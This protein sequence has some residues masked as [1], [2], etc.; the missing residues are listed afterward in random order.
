MRLS[1]R[2]RHP[3]A[4]Q[5]RLTPGSTS[6]PTATSRRWARRRC[7]RCSSC[8]STWCGASRRPFSSPMGA[9]ATGAQCRGW[10]ASASGLLC[11]TSWDALT[12]LLTLGMSHFA[13]WLVGRAVL[14]LASTLVLGAGLGMPAAI[15]L[16][17][18][19]ACEAIAGTLILTWS[20][21]EAWGPVPPPRHRH[22][23]RPHIRVGWPERVHPC[24]HG[25]PV[26]HHRLRH[27]V[28]APVR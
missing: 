15:T 16:L 2:L 6:S 14:A 5:S 13:A 22:R 12:T 7:G 1:R 9:P 28:A 26:A 10:A 21:V 20:R 18:M 25:A 27:L 23:R 3:V 8:P 4:V 17:A 11:C 24:S 19:L